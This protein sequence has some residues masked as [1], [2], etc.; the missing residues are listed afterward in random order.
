MS[1]TAM[2]ATT[3]TVSDLIER[4]ESAIT[5]LAAQLGVTATAASVAEIVTDPAAQWATSSVLSGRSLPQNTATLKALQ[6]A[7]RELALAF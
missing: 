2:S 7:V 1:I 4:A 5:A 6:F 3:S